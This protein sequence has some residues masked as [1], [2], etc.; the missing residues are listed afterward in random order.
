MKH[1]FVIV[2]IGLSLVLAACAPGGAATPTTEVLP[3]VI[4]DST[5][6]AEGRLEPIRFAEIAF[7]TSGRIS[8]VLV[9]E[10]TLVKKGEEFIRLG[11]AVAFFGLAIWRFRFE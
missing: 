6:I 10:G 1:K 4:A 11:D 2:L 7:T 8:D 3:T 5:I 9:Q